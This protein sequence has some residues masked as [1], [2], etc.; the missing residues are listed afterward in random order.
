MV[1]IKP[2]FLPLLL[3]GIVLA[4][5]KVTYPVGKARKISSKVQNGYKWLTGLNMKNLTEVDSKGFLIVPKLADRD[6]GA[7]KFNPASHDH[8]A[9]S[10]W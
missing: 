10:C 3:S 7:Q 6:A 1:Q 8:N 9:G 4:T 2:S 5:R